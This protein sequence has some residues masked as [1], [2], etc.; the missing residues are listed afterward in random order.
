MLEVDIH[1]VAS[2]IPRFLRKFGV[3]M[4]ILSL[5]AGDYRVPGRYVI[6]RKTVTDLSQSIISGRIFAQIKK[7]LQCEEKVIFIVEGD[8][9]SVRKYSN[10]RLESLTGFI[11]SLQFDFGIPVIFSYNIVQSALYLKFLQ[12]REC[13]RDKIIVDV[14]RL[15]VI[16]D[17]R[18][19]VLCAFE[20][21]GIKSAL[22]LLENFGS[23]KRVFDADFDDLAKVIGSSR[24]EKLL[25]LL[26]QEG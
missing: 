10:I 18:L 24:A 8:I 3:K 13:D 15:R 21:I 23:L 1:E 12:Q 11:V 14:R 22:K 25:R 6:E 19:R 26:N 9:H 2:G 20:G 7:L 16:D 17:P 4:E 5:S